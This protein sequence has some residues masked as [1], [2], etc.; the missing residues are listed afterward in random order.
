[1][2][3]NFFSTTDNLLFKGSFKSSK[4]NQKKEHVPY[5]EVSIKSR[6]YPE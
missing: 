4:H 1:M 6:P 2:Y 5:L 3:W